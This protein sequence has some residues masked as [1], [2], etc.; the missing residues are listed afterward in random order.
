[1]PPMSCDHAGPREVMEMAEKNLAERGASPENGMRFR[2][3]EN[4][5]GFFA[6]A[7]TEIERRN[8][9]WVVV[10]LD[11]LEEPLP[12]GEIGLTRLT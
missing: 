9:E 5:D 3:S 7:I 12:A 6:A 8:G 10:R 1:M 4:H 11:R 2:W